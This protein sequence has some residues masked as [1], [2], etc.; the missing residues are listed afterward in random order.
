MCLGLAQKGSYRW[1]CR[2]P[3]DIRSAQ[4][5]DEP[6]ACGDVFRPAGQ[7]LDAARRA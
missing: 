4:K 5:V 1:S 3:K 2:P 6:R 7:F